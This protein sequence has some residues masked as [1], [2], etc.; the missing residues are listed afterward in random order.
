MRPIVRPCHTH[1]TDP[2]SFFFLSFL[3]SFFLNSLLFFFSSSWLPF[4]FSLFS[5]FSQYSHIFMVLVSFLFIEFTQILH[6][7]EI[8]KHKH[9]YWSNPE[10]QTHNSVQ[11]HINPQISSPKIRN[12]PNSQTREA[13]RERGKREP[14]WGNPHYRER[15]GCRPG[16]EKWVDKFS[17]WSKFCHV[18][19]EFIRLEICAP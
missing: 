8:W 10:I 18:E 15:E 13:M 14:T 16:I 7:R 4:F 11:S 1:M 5:F 12:P 19:I 3:F 2:L 9:V 6:I 17:M